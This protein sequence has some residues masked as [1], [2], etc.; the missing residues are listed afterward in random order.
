MFGLDDINLER[1]VLISQLH[2]IKT[3]RLEGTMTSTYNEHCPMIRQ[4]SN[5][6]ILCGKKIWRT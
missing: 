5:M 1:E 6:N 4:R 2:P 3:P